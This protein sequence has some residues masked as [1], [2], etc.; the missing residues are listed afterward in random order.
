MVLK[1]SEC[2]GC[3]AGMG[4][5]VIQQ[6]SLDDLDLDVDVIVGVIVVGFVERIAEFVVAAVI[7]GVVVWECGFARVGAGNGVVRIGYWKG[8][9]L[10]EIEQRGVGEKIDK[11]YK[12][13]SLFGSR[14][15]KLLVKLHLWVQ[16]IAL[17]LP[18]HE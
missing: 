12:G 8:N 1:F 18:M 2:V 10:E 4:H 5:A 6:L 9:I 14:F 3:T 7:V 15:G 13:M 11:H 16:N 17:R